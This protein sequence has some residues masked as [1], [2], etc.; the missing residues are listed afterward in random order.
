MLTALAAWLSLAAPAPADDPPPAA[1]P[2][3]PAPLLVVA[4]VKDGKLVLRSTQ[5]VYQTRIETQV[6]VVNGKPI[7]Y[8]IARTEA[9]PQVVE[10]A[11]PLEDV[12]VSDGAGKKVDSGEAAKRLARPTLVLQSVDGKP[13]DPFYLRAFRKGSLVITLPGAKPGRMPYDPPRKMPRPK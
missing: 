11:H 12:Q 4:Q 7:S 9:V 3:T 10:R 6:R 13:V 2:K 5:T 8:Q 1:P